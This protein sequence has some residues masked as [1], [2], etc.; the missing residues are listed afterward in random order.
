[1]SLL[2]LFTFTIGPSIAKAILK[3]WLKDR[4]ILS[5]VVP[6][7][8]DLLK[9]GAQAERQ[10]G[11]SAGRIEALGVQVVQQM[12]PIFDEAGRGLGEGGR[13]AVVQELA[14]TLAAARIQPRLLIDC[15]L[16]PALLSRQLATA[17][18]DAVKLLSAGESAVYG[19]LLD[20]AA[21][22]ITQIATELNG[23][24]TAFSAATLQDHDK[25]LAMLGDLWRRPDAADRE[26][27]DKYL[28]LVENKL[29]RL[30]QFGL[31]RLDT[32]TRAQRLTRVYISLQ[33][34]RHRLLDADELVIP[35]ES[36]QRGFFDQLD[37]LFPASNPPS[38][39]GRLERLVP[40][41]GDIDQILAFARRLVIRGEAGSGKSTLL[42]WLAVRSASRSFTGPLHGWNNTVPFFIR[43]RERVDRNFPRPEDFPVL[44]APAIA[45]TL[46]QGWVHRQLESGRALVLI[47][48]VDE[49]PEGKREE[50]LQALT[51]L[52][53]AYPLARY[54]VTSRPA[55]LKRDDWPAWSE[56]TTGE[57][58]T[59]AT[60][61]PMT[62]EQVNSLIRQWHAAL[63][64]KINDSEERA[65]ILQ[66]PAT[67][68][69][70]LRLR[71]A[72]RRLTTNPL[73]CSMICALHRDSREN[74]PNERVELYEQCVD[75][76]LTKRDEGRKVPLGPEYA[77]LTP[78]QQLV[79]VQNFAYWMMRN[80]YSDVS[81]EEADQHFE[82]K[83]PD[84]DAPNADGRN[85][86]RFFAERTNLIREPVDD[87]IDFTHRTF[88][89]FLAAQ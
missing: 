81:V 58:F 13:A 40:Q 74:L 53:M 50:L 79:L 61:Q 88:Q 87:R 75:M 37:E 83:L 38:P 41:K 85:V 89:E 6:E 20:E 26:F 44:I 36:L 51:D 3:T 68:A 64:E 55:A 59:D 31:P 45:G 76:L 82:A 39:K 2:G 16:D 18:P 21:R 49:L 5:S 33:F 86:R 62:P 23:F 66:L 78:G 28:A 67:L 12:Q 70:T 63:A 60:L 10:Q 17:R 14:A 57:G 35:D 34:E 32:T 43:L 52:V 65:E 69:R 30:E 29:D 9:T 24:N 8:L 84:L 7:L 1:M 54:I 4:P 27:E 19:R 15:N 11:Q 22:G 56:W 77:R 46:P 42:Q 73:L 72:L 25:I 47:D 80:G 71:P 48:G